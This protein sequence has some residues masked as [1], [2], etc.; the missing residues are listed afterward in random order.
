MSTRARRSPGYTPGLDTYLQDVADAA[1]LSRREER[2]L[3]ARGFIPRGIVMDSG[4]SPRDRIQRALVSPVSRWHRTL[5]GRHADPSAPRA[6]AGLAPDPPGLDRVL[7]LELPRMRR[8]EMAVVEA[9]NGI[10]PAPRPRHPSSS[11]CA[12]TASELPP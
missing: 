3:A 2:E 10:S 4:T 12:P 5:A 6:V 8:D 7:A 1:P 11:P 9:V